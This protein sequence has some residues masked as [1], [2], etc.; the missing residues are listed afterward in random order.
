MDFPDDLK[1]LDTYPNTKNILAPLSQ[2]KGTYWYGIFQGNRN[3]QEMFCPSF[4][5]W[6][7]GKKEF[8]DMA[9]ICPLS[10]Y[11]HSTAY[12]AYLAVY[13]SDD[14]LT[15]ILSDNLSLEGSVS[16]IVNERDAIVA[17]SDLSLSGIYQ[18]DYDTI[19]ASF[20]SSNNF[21]ERNILDTK[22]YA[23][24]YSISNTDWFMVTVLP[25][26]P[27]IHAS[28]RLMVQIVLIYAVFLVLALIFCQCTGSFHYRKTF[29]CDP[30]DAD[31]P[32][33]PAYSYGKS[34]GT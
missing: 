11:Y 3:T 21:I 10:L 5:L 6:S 32:P 1:T 4:Y 19:K 2:A 9:Y 33:R 28:N 23:G 18:L 29:F 25:S 12:K 16:Y 13:Y 7:Q 14:K 31:R 20:M 24:F 27:L 8:G 15:S 30:A 17:T 26:P 34:T 22:V